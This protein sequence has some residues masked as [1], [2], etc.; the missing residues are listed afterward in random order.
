[1][2]NASFYQAQTDAY[3]R[4]NNVTI[5]GN[6]YTPTNR[7]GVRNLFAPPAPGNPD[8][9]PV[10]VAI[11]CVINSPSHAYRQLIV[12]DFYNGGGAIDFSNQIANWRRLIDAVQAPPP[13]LTEARYSENGFEFT[14]AGQRGRTN[15]V[16][17]T[18]NFVD[19]VTVTNVFGTNAPVVIR[20]PNTAPNDQRFYRVVRP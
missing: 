5:C 8:P 16:E 6:D 18:L 7:F 11:N 14:I 20:D 12:K 10:F 17:S 3:L 9:R 1:M 15:R 19:W 4:N 2:E 13:K